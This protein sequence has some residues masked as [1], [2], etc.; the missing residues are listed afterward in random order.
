[1]SYF[2][3][4][5][6]WR[7]GYSAIG[8][9]Q[10][11]LVAILVSSLPLWKRVSNGQQA[12]E[13]AGK[14][15]SIKELL[16]IKGA[17]QALATFFCYCAVESTTGLWGS[18]FLVL[19]RGISPETAASW[20]SLYYFGITFGR[21]MSGFLTMRITNKKLVRIGLCMIVLGILLIMVPT[22]DFILMCGFFMIGLGCA[23]VFPSLIHDTPENFGSDVS[24]SMIGL[25]M[26]CAYI[27][28][29]AM[30]PL[31]GLVGQYI[32]MS[33]LPFYLIIIT[34]VMISMVERLNRIKADKAPSQ[35][36]DR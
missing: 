34:V 21:F 32:S 23:P 36:S 7:S 16:G 6:G 2:L 14:V 28:T 9:I 1:M 12:A 22:V 20:V 4:R 33:L 15:F 25:Q 35:T 27:G 3:A 11:V 5:S 19:S 24:Q 18:S 13:T 8:W 29:T 30:P 31:F 10:T 26:A 17:K